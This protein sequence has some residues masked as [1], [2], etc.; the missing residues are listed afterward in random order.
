ML[1]KWKYQKHYVGERIE[2]EFAD[3]K[4]IDKSGSIHG[5]VESHSHQEDIDSLV[6]KNYGFS[7]LSLRG[8]VCVS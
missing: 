8:N 1:L 5:I 7:L 4:F 6:P 2:F 3:S